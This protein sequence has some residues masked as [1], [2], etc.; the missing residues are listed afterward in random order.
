MRCQ[1]PLY[2]EKLDSTGILATVR[3]Y[4]V[5]VVGIGD[6]SIGLPADLTGL[7]TAISLGIVHPDSSHRAKSLIYEYRYPEI[8][9]KLES[10]Q[11]VVA[12]MLRMEGWR[13]LII[14]ADTSKRQDRLI[15]RIHPLFPHKTGATCAGLGWVG[16]SGLLVSPGY[17][18]GLS[19]ASV[20]TNAPY[21]PTG[22][23]YLQGCCGSCTACVRACPAGAISGQEWKRGAQYETM[24]DI[25]ACAQQ[26]ERNFA[27]VGELACGLCIMACR[28]NKASIPLRRDHSV[29]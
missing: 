6:I 18:P 24:V 9:R 11:E 1:A 23:P 25:A 27:R 29:S 21:R 2:L 10:V 15:S 4:G 3:G 16:K 22:E 14:P 17:G 20:L 19:W 28:R 8:D 5:D 26:L 12:K 7:A 13:F